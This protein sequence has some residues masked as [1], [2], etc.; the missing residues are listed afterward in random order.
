MLA[1]R[2]IIGHPLT[3][4]VELPLLIPAF[5]SKGFRLRPSK[6][7]RKKHDYSEI[8][9]QLEHFGQIP[10][11]PVLISAY[12][13]HFQ[14][15]EDP[16][17]P[18]N[19]PEDFLQNTCLVFLDSGG[20]ELIPDF[21]STE[22]KKSGHKP[23]DGY[24][25]DQYNSVIQQLYDRK[26]ALPLVIANFDYEMRGQ[27]VAR[28]ISSARETFNRFPDYMSDFIL[29]PWTPDSNIVDPSRLS[30]R[31]FENLR[32]FDVIGVTEKELG[33][34]LF[35][36]LKRIAKFRKRLDNANISAPIHVWG[37]L[38]PIMTPLFFFAGASIFDGVSW[39]R[40]AYWDGVAMNRE[41]YA[42]LSEIGV[43]ASHKLNH[44]YAS[45]DN[46]TFI[47]NMTISLQQWVDFDGK[48]FDMFDPHVRK[49]IE[50]AY[51]TMSSKIPELKGDR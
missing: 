7:I 15:F 19:R 24:G 48:K 40:Y 12:D 18:V 11:T 45:L 1:R 9:S 49:P 43:F 20:Y 33:S 28:Q 3:G 8:S 36:R 27:P 10:E 6:K 31:D 25:W 34:D 2:G 26:Q 21:D 39:L 30:D 29:K 17:L 51:K 23:K 22:V 38:D 14:H 44:T 32:G 50:R 47:S 37:G 46:L 5:S 13:L 42:V 4:E 16:E 35:D 41:S